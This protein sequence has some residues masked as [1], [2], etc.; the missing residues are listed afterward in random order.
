[1]HRRLGRLYLGDGRCR[2]LLG[3]DLSARVDL[4]DD[5][6]ALLGLQDATAK[7]DQCDHGGDRQHGQNQL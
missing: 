4:V 1:M 5:D 2:R 3:H 7:D 6:A